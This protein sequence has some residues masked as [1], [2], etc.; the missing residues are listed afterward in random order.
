[1][2]GRQFSGQ[3]RQ[4]PAMLTTSS[5][6]ENPQMDSSMTWPR[7]EV[8]TTEYHEQISAMTMSGTTT[9][10]M[11]AATT[12]PVT[13]AVARNITAHWPTKHSSAMVATERPTTMLDS[14]VSNITW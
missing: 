3:R 6:A 9:R 10:E 14:H 8:V 1:M 12:L 2:A 4:I 7:F 13:C 5:A 11:A